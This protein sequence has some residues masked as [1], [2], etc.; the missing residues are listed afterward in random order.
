MVKDPLALKYFR[1]EDEEYALLQMLDGAHSADR[2]KLKWDKKF[3]PQKI[4]LAELF[5]FIGML[6]RSSLLMSDA[7]GQGVELKHRSDDQQRRKLSAGF[8]NVLAIRFRGFDPGW[9]LGLTQSL[10]G[11]IFSWPAFAMFVLLACTALGLIAVEWEAFQNKLPRFQEMFA[12]SNWLL[13]ALTLAFTKVLHELGHGT[14]CRKFGG[15]CHEMGVML[16]VFTPCLYCNVSDSWTLPSKWKRAAIGG[17]GMYVE[18]ILASCA[19]LIWWFSHEGIVHSLALNVMFVCS[20]STLLFNA[21]PLL[22]YD[23]YYILSDLIEVPNLRQKAS[24]IMNR[25][26]S[27]WVLGIQSAQD[28]FMPTRNKWLFAAYSLAAAVYKWVVTLAIFWFLYN[29]LE[30]YGLKVLG[31]ML[32]LV[33]LYGLVAMPLI[34]FVR[35]L[36]VPGRAGSVKPA[37]LTAALVLGGL[38]M[39]GILLIP[40]PHYVHCHLILQNTSRDSVYVQRTGTINTLHAESDEWVQQGQVLLTLDSQALTDEIVELENQLAEAVERLQFFRSYQHRDP[41]AH[42]EVEPARIDAVNLQG[43]LE[44]KRAELESLVVRAPHTGVLLA[45]QRVAPPPHD[46]GELGNWNGSPLE[47]RN[48]GALVEAGTVVGHITP[49]P[50]AVEGV[51]AIDQAYIEFIAAGQNVEFILDQVPGKKFASRIDNAAPVEMK[52]APRGL[53]SRFGGEV[54]TRESE[55][56]EDRPLSTTYRLAVPVDLSEQAAAFHGATGVARIR[57]GNQTVGQR[58]WRVAC[59]TFHFRL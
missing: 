2:I 15:Q 29:L 52:H 53:S 20:V 57:T 55:T 44:K 38:A 35:F 5:Q 3:A 51:L 30:P 26:L 27:R 37:N 47:P 24:A 6:Y 45:P 41:D 43:L 42:A 58:V 12:T 18:F 14:A 49:D 4:S 56:G 10:F 59:E 21:N 46:S 16:L 8:T 13:L 23:G 40:I 31:Q 39:G 1:F 11:W 19:T 28:P 36:K 32:A 7:A 50:T 48:L 25:F 9:L 22:R 54:M 34:Q 33:S 17:A